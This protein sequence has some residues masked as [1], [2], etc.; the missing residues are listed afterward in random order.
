MDMQEWQAYVKKVANSQYPV[1]EGMIK[2]YDDWRCRSIVGRMLYVLEDIEG[3]IAVLLTVK[4]IKPNLQDVPEKGLSEAEHMVLC[5]RDIAE[6]IYKVMGNVPIAITYLG[7][8][9]QICRAYKHPFRSADKGGVWHRSLELMEEIGETEKA[10]AKAEAML[11]EEK[12]NFGKNPYRYYANIY[13]AKQAAKAEGYAKG[14]ELIA[15]A[16]KYYPVNDACQTFL[17]TA[18]G[19]E[20]PGQQGRENNA[21][22]G[23]YRKEQGRKQTYPH[24]KKKGNPGICAK[25]GHSFGT[26]FGKQPAFVTLNDVLNPSRIPGKEAHQKQ[27][28]ASWGDSQ[29]TT[30]DAFISL[31][32]YIRTQVRRED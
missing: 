20:D 14:A 7:H 24:S 11:E 12:D 8:A 13:L 4:D 5:L 28:L 19:I 29:K 6:I 32:L 25:R 18:A 26:I 27:M 22:Q 17:N 3:A 2:N 9:H 30:E 23:K 21:N 31:F 10:I 1:P 15:E 16:Y